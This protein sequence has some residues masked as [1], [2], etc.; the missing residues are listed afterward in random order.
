MGLLWLCGGGE[1][2]DWYEDLPAELQPAFCWNSVNVIGQKVSYIC[3]YC[4]VLTVEPKQHL[5]HSQRCMVDLIAEVD[6][7]RLCG[8]K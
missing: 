8:A 6:K 7:I 2:N 4:T 5:L 1:M 3:R